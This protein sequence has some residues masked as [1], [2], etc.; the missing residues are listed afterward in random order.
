MDNIVRLIP[1]RNDFLSLLAKNPTKVV[2]IKFGAT[3]CG[4]C[5]KIA[6]LVATHFSNMPNNV[7]CCDL[8][9]DTNTDVYEFLRSKKMVN[10]IPTILCFRGSNMISYVP[11]FSAIG[12]NPKDINTFFERVVS[13]L[14]TPE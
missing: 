6:G 8:D 13:I 4:P 2:V 12:A 5:K 7:I 11:D 14:T 10:A 3:W 9:V 1:N